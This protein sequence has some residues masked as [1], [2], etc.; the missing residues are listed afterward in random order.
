MVGNVNPVT[1][2]SFASNSEKLILPELA[3]G[4]VET[5]NGN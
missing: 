4:F 1:S 5:L 3:A 2:V